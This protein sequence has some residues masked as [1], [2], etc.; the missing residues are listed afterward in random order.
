[1]TASVPCRSCGAPMWWA[2][3]E[4]GK[5]IPLDDQPTP[6]GNLAVHRDPNGVLHARGLVLDEEPL[7]HEHRAT[8]HFATCP[9]A[10]QHRRRR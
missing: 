5:A 7:E 1:M 4:A 10:N 6:D 9:H 2:T 3:T 8:S